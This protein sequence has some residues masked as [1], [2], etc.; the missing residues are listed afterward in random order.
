M[1]QGRKQSEKK[2]YVQTNE[3]E[4]KLSRIFGMFAKAVLRGQFIARE[5][6]RNNTKIS[7]KQSNLVPQGTRKEQ[8]ELKTS[9]KKK[10]PNRLEQKYQKQ[11]LKNK[12]TD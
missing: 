1:G 11:R 3:H 12:R 2:K 5:P 9:R 10:T 7:N 8:L 4:K 6:S